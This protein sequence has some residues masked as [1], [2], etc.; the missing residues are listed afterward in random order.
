M[1]NPTY[2]AVA[3]LGMNVLQQQQQYQAAK[4]QAAA[5]ELRNKEARKS[6]NRAYLS[7]LAALDREKQNEL[8]DAA[9]EKEG[10][11]LQNIKKQDE[12]LLDG[13]EKGNANV[14]AVLRDVGFEYQSEFSKIDR[15]MTDL[16]INNIFGQ[17]DAYSA[18]RR[19]YSKVPDVIQP[20]KLGL[21]IGV[22]GSAL[23]T[24]TDYKAGKYGKSNSS[25]L[26]TGE[27]S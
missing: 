3:A 13:L 22:A 23:G 4:D 18:F 5:Q 7:D 16:N 26:D 15:G 14:E 19:S 20:N 1:C 24:Y 6:A 17:D 11:E 27:I 10:L 2:I 8:A 25:D 9:A 21:A 12:A